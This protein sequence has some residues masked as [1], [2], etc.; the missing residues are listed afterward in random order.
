MIFLETSSHQPAFGL[1]THTD[2][3]RVSFTFNTQLLRC[4]FFPLARGT[5]FRVLTLLLAAYSVS[6]LT[7]LVMA[8]L[9]WTAWQNHGGTSAVSRAKSIGWVAMCDFCNDPENLLTGCNRWKVVPFSSIRSSS[10]SWPAMSS[11]LTSVTCSVAYSLIWPILSSFGPSLA[12][13]RTFKIRL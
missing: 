6:I 13:L 10:L 12:S 4:F 8:S 1:A 5:G 11:K 7:L 3:S 2:E 9:L